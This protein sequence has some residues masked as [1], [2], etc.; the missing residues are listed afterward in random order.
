MRGTVQSGVKSGVTPTFKVSQ[1]PK[2]TKK[3][4]PR[5]EEINQES[6][7]YGRRNENVFKEKGRGQNFSQRQSETRTENVL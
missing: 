1:L 6:L 4:Q 5:T 3:S 2:D 7:L